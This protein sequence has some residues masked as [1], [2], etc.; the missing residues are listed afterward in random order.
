MMVFLQGVGISPGYALKIYQTYKNEAIK[1]VRE[2]PY[3]LA[4]DVQG[5]GFK[6]ADQIARKVGT[7]PDSPYRIRRNSVFIK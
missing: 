6:I 5:I 2:N 3:R 4:D 7:H 1:V